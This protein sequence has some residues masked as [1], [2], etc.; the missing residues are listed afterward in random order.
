VGFVVLVRI[1]TVFGTR[2]EAIK[3]APVIQA[4]QRQP[5]VTH[6]TCVTGQHREMLA[7]VL[8]VFGLIPDYDLAVMAPGQ[9]L[10]QVTT[11]VL[12]GVGDVINQA[13]PDWVVV[14]GDT[15]T[16]FAGAL[17]AFYSKVKIA[18]VEA[19]LRT[20]NLQSPW[21]EEANR[22]LISQLA[23]LHFAP[24]QAAA[25]QLAAENIHPSTVV[26]TGNTVVDALQWAAARLE[27]H[28]QIGEH[29]GFLSPSKKLILVTG[30][31]RESFDGGLQRVCQALR[32]ISSRDDVQIVY[33]VHLNPRVAQIAATA[34]DRV[35]NTHL[36]APQS[37][38]HFVWL[39]RQAHLILTDSGGI[40]EEAPSFGKPVLVTR[41]A[42]ER[43]EAL[44]AGLAKLV[45]T[46]PESIVQAV[47]ALLDEPVAYAKMAEAKNPFGDGKAA[48]RIAQ[49]LSWG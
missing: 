45:G 24:T 41:E 3:L 29:F 46:S 20:G 22:K 27:A 38:L 8:N 4:L 6:Q 17:A 23:T 19:G 39:M 34:L 37:Y 14:Q 49:R 1:L 32:E 2:P 18:H 28:P 26:V 15:T 12:Q 13:Q 48:L 10:T 31:R 30:H 42:T 36:I 5:G 7:D 33:P 40:Q 43:P 25:D 9:D 11:R 44:Q 35:P 21:P 16:A 47:T